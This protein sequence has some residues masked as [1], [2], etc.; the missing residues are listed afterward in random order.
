V[1]R[2][3]NGTTLTLETTGDASGGL[4]IQALDVDGRASTKAW[5][6][7]SFVGASATLRIT[8]G[9]APAREWAAAPSDA[10]PSFSPR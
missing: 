6:P 5:L 3:G 4:Y 2:R 1:I 8:V 9:S 10:P 7:E